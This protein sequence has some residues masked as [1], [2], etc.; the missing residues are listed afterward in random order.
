VKQVQIFIFGYYGWKNTGDDAMLYILLQE[1]PQLYPEAQFAVISPVPVIIPPSVKD[2]VKFIRPAIM[3]VFREIIKSRIF[4]IGGGTHIHD[5]AR[6]LRSIK[7]LM[8]LLAIVAFARISGNKVYLIGNGIGP[9]DKNWSKLITRF[10]CHISDKIT[11]R[12]EASY[13]VI[14][15]L[16]PV[17]MKKVTL[18]FDLAAL[19][20]PV[21]DP[22]H[23][24]TEENAHKEIL[25]IC[26]TSVFEIYYGKKE[27]DLLIIDK[28]AE[29]VNQWLTKR[30]QLQVHLFVFKDGYRD[31]DVR[32]TELLK[33]QLKP[34]ECVNLISYNPN[35]IQTLTQVARCSAFVGTKYHSCLFAYLNEIPLLVIDYHPKCRYFVREVGL[36]EHALLSLHE[37]LNGQFGKRLE[38]LVESPGSF[39]ATLPV[40]IARNR[41]K[42]GITKAGLS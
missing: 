25:G 11:V 27:K 12:D 4:I 18:G 30:P 14:N 1:L 7:T 17:D 21:S 20:N 6:S 2:K 32:I 24:I 8:R 15:T 29:V 36:P 37:I 40:N 13:Q 5:Y 41:A 42:A 39:R 23:A 38:Y 31:S 9:I 10:I 3:P 26:I 35:P 28:I 34:T 19:L 33:E 16:V 22:P